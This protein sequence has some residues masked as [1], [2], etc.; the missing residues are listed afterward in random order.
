VPIDLLKPVLDEMIRTGTTRLAQ[1]RPW[2]GVN[3]LEED[4]RVKVLQVNDG[5]PAA[6]AGI[7]AG[8]I[9]LAIN[10]QTVDKLEDFYR[11]LWDGGEPGVTFRLSVLHGPQVRT[12]DATGLH[13]AGA[14]YAPSRRWSELAR[15]RETANFFFFFEDDRVSHYLPKRVLTDVE[16][17]ELRNLIQANR[18]S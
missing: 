9:I 4:G 11:T 15:A 13:V 6:R 17:D 1:H 16:R 10:G 18:K 5:G 14:G 8:D 3:S 12:V 2:L 7:E